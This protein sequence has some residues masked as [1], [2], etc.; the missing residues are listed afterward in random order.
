MEEDEFYSPRVT[1]PLAASH[2][3]RKSPSA[4]ILDAH[5]V[6]PDPKTWTVSSTSGYMNK[7]R[8]LG[9]LFPLS[10]AVFFR[11]IVYSLSA[12]VENQILSVHGGISLT[13]NTIDKIWAIDRKQEAPQE[14]PM[15]DLLWCGNVAAI[16]E[17][18]AYLKQRFCVFEA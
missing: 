11:T 2:G 18:H 16:L 9:N 5:M 13:I 14:G 6:E 10:M 1:E 12:L 8:D 7:H 17:L 15:R 3:V 4:V